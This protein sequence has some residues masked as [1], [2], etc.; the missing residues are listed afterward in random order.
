MD[1]NQ[2]VITI[3]LNTFTLRR[4]RIASFA[5]IIKIATMFIK[6]IFQD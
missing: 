3:I 4:S 1:R 2:D 6:K 5:D